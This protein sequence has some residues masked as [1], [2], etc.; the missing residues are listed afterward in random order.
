MEAAEAKAY[1][2]LASNYRALEALVNTLLTRDNLTGEE[3][4]QVLEEA[5]EWPPIVPSAC[6]FVC[7]HVF[8]FE[9]F[10]QQSDGGRRSGRCWRRR[11]NRTLPWGQTLPFCSEL[12]SSAF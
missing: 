11:A 8:C 4:R 3:V 10:Q 7:G 6:S 5:G 2:G 12:A 9:G 1:Y